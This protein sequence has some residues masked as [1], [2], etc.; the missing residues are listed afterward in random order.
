M[1]SKTKAFLE[2]GRLRNNLK[3]DVG[4]PEC[5][6]GS[7]EG[8]LE[9]PSSVDGLGERRID[10]VEGDGVVVG[11][12]TMEFFKASQATLSCPNI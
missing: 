2:V 10:L 3:N 1:S 6:M 11:E 4:S 12:T 5:N 8:N 7:P 9:G